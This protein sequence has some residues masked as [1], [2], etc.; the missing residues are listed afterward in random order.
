MQSK[1]KDIVPGHVHETTRKSQVNDEWKVTRVTWEAIVHATRVA[2]H[3]YHFHALSADVVNK[4]S[5]AE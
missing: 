2:V 3:V 4:P 5:R 1:A